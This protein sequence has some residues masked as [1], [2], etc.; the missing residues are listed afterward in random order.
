MTTEFSKKFPKR[1]VDA[2]NYLTINLEAM[3]SE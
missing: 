3:L 1:F 2:M